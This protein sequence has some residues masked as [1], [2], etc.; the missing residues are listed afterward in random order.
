MKM[1]SKIDNSDPSKPYLFESE[2]DLI[3]FEN[4]LKETIITLDSTDI[5]GL[6]DED[7]DRYIPSLPHNYEPREYQLPLWDF[8]NF[9]E[10]G[11]IIYDEKGYC[12]KPEFMRMII[13]W[14][15]RAGKDINLWNI[16][17]LCALLKPG[18]YWYLLP[19]AKQGRVAIFDSIAENGYSFLSYLPKE[20]IHPDQFKSGSTT[21]WDK[22]QMKTRLINGSLIQIHGSDNYDRLVGANA[23]GVVF[24]EYSLSNPMAWEYISPMIAQTGGFAWFVYTPRG[25]NHGYDLIEKHKDDPDW[26]I[27]IKDVYETK[28]I[29]PEVIE[30]EK[31]DNP[32]FNQE[33]LCDFHAP[34]V[35]AY[36]SEQINNVYDENRYTNLEDLENGTL[37]FSTFKVAMD[38]GMNDSNVLIF[39][40]EYRGKVY[41]IHYYE[42]NGKAMDYYISEILRFQNYSKLK[43]EE[44]VLPHDIRTREYSTGKTRF[45]YLSE[46]INP[47]GQV[48]MNVLKRTE[49]N[50]GI[51]NVRRV[52]PSCIFVNNERYLVHYEQS[53]KAKRNIKILLQRLGSYQKKPDHK[54]NTF[55][56]K[57]L[58]DSNTHAADGFRYLAIS[59]DKLKLNDDLTGIIKRKLMEGF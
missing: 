5:A 14:N 39:F 58:R 31:R 57:P 34:V 11:N 37:P 33:Y 49:L 12:I 23:S 32:K 56:D 45:D 8:I 28:S 20:Y 27:S 51:E 30:K 18:V 35:G 9:D 59:V 4:Y 2:N 50:D 19:T 54:N 38:L 3:E 6:R 41:I 17:L 7:V 22:A 13:V 53:G 44:L 43:L 47:K 46:R 42:D 1:M 21:G 24:S 10:N 48:F 40:Q 36:Y 52:L 25:R 55:F 26:Y 16:F 29:P 15:R